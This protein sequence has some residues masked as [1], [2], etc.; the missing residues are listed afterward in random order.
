MKSSDIYFEIMTKLMRDFREAGKPFKQQKEEFY[1][2][3]DRFRRHF[4]IEQHFKFATRKDAE[5]RLA[6]LMATN[7]FSEGELLVVEGADLYL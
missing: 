4:G 6:E 5:K 2:L 3:R 7:N 1:E